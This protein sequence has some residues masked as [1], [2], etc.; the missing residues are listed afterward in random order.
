METAPSETLAL[1]KRRRQ[2]VI[3]GE[4]RRGDL[5]RDAGTASYL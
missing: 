4:K 1:G 3:E 2:L 5:Q